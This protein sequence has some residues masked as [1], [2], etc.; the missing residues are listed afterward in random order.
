M[1]RTC[2]ALY[3][4]IISHSGTNGTRQKKWRVKNAENIGGKG[5]KQNGHRTGKPVAH[6]NEPSYDYFNACVLR[7]PAVT[8]FFGFSRI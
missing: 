3:I 5:R 7:Y 2:D 4:H 6:N 1:L 8:A